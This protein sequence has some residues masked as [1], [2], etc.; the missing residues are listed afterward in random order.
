[1]RRIAIV[2]SRN[3]NPAQVIEDRLTAMGHRYGRSMVVV[4][5]GEPTG[6]D[7]TARVVAESLGI[8]VVEHLPKR[9]E[10]KEFFARNTLIANDCDEL[11]AL[12][13]PGP[14]SPGTSDTLAKAR[15]R[16]I[17]TFVHHEGRWMAE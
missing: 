5:G 13:A 17:P 10:R 4:S 2:G 14:R 7:K 11:W 16:G 6:V 9:K 12:F 15:R 1:V 3:Y 8:E